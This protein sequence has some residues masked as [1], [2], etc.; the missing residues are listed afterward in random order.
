MAL[1]MPFGR[2]AC[3][4]FCGSVFLGT[5]ALVA[6]LLFKPE[7]LRV[8]YRTRLWQF[9]LLTMLSFSALM[10][11]GRLLM[12]NPIAYSWALPAGARPK[13]YAALSR[14]PGGSAQGSAGPG[15][16]RSTPGKPALLLSSAGPAL[17]GSALGQTLGVNRLDVGPGAR[18]RM[19][20]KRFVLQ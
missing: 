8:V 11:S 3:A 6:H 12:E 2:L 9:P 10:L 15:M 18:P 17:N 7:E 20:L 13:A 14:P 19:E 16:A 1:I 4:V 5:T